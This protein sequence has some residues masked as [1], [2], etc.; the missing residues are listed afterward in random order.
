MKGPSSLFDGDALHDRAASSI[1]AKG[2]SLVALGYIEPFA[3]PQPEKFPS[4]RR[5]K[6][7]I[8]AKDMAGTP[9][10]SLIDLVGR[11]L[12]RFY[13]EEGQNVGLKGEDYTKLRLTAETILKSAP[14]S[15]GLS[16]AFVEEK[17]FEWWTSR[18]R[19]QPVGTLS[20]FMLAAAEKAIKVHEIIIP[21]SC[22]EFEKA[23]QYGDVLIAPMD[24]SLL[25]GSADHFANQ[26]PAKA[27]AIR[28]SFCELDEEMGHQTTVQ[29]TLIGEPEFASKRAQ[30]I[31][32]EVT[33]VF[34]FMSPAAVSW[35][36][37]F[38]CFPSGC[39][40]IRRITSLHI[41]DGHVSIISGSIIDHGLFSWRVEFD[42]LDRY[43]KQGFGGAAIFFEDK[44]L[45]D[46]QERIRTSIIHYANGV[47]LQ[48]VSDRLVYV[49]S[50]LEHLF[51]RGSGELIQ[52][53]V[54]ERIAFFTKRKSSE[55]RE[56]VKNFKNA[57]QLRSNIVHHLISVENEPVLT[58]FFENAY[59]AVHS[60]M[61]S[62]YKFRT[63]DEFLDAIDSVKFGGSS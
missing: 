38:P 27:D 20:S 42:D 52:N 57:Y 34:R 47:A 59:I 35:N 24:R 30:A 16:N 10:S 31:A 3:K 63:R 49:M 1:D 11:T 56:L 19:N 54:A 5:P 32:F 37:P 14:F 29:V 41:K 22:I 9:K 12:G 62:M 48:N 23:F 21:I 18:K 58:K 33:A 8:T 25:Q 53:N 45:S 40:H 46:F 4:R 6:A 17:I 28:A 55:R 7:T 39:E 51:L 15:S 50:A 36:V 43:M 26:N 2:E 61:V 13:A 60:A 44:A